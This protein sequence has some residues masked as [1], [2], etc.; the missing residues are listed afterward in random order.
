MKI[1]VVLFVVLFVAGC[2]TEKRYY[3]LA[4]SG[5]RYYPAATIQKKEVDPKVAI[6]YQI[7]RQ[8]YREMQSWQEQCAALRAGA[9]IFYPQCREIIGD[10][11]DI[12]RKYQGILREL[13]G[14]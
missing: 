7:G 12:P 3:P 2:A 8:M 6:A 5:K 4:D 9:P 13:N 10:D 14:R 11:R 1:P